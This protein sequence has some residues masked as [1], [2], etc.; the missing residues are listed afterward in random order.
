[1]RILDKIV[2]IVVVSVGLKV[3]QIFMEK[4][5]IEKESTSKLL[6]FINF[7]RDHPSY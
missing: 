5:T 1:M 3:D 2:C 7:H 6:S 4:K